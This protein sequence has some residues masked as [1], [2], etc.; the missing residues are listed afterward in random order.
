M[1][2]S[3][4]RM[5]V[6]LR[7]ATLNSLQEI[8]SIPLF[9]ISLLDAKEIKEESMGKEEMTLDMESKNQI[10]EASSRTQKD[11]SPKVAGIIL[12]LLALG[13]GVINLPSFL[14]LHEN[15]VYIKVIWRFMFL[16]IILVPWLIYDITNNV[17]RMP[18][19]ITANISPILLLSLLY[20]G[21]VY[22]IYHAVTLTFVAHTVLLF[23]IGTTFVATWKIARSQAYTRLEYL[24]I[25]A[26]VFGAYLC[27]CEG[28]I[29]YSTESPYTSKENLLL[30]DFLSIASA[31]LF[32]FYN[33]LSSDLIKK[34]S[35]PTSVYFTMLSVF[36]IGLS[37]VFAA[38]A[39][40]YV[41]LNADPINGLLGVFAT[42]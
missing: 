1:L 25:A 33:E 35:I 8:A 7:Q 21:F 32:A 4:A 11:H 39:G 28:A 41:Y 30:G 13:G 6:E 9:S 15:S 20:S 31:A 14:K 40:K 2:K 26:N 42:K 23:S 16:L 24:G 10:E 38:S 37:F 36:I 17:A 19:L 5:P 27:C 34:R 3:Y 18:E 12:F 29:V 22:L